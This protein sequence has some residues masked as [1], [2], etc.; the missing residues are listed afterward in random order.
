MAA[1]SKS[2]LVLAGCG[3]ASFIAAIFLFL[4]AYILNDSKVTGYKSESSPDDFVVYHNAREGRTGPLLE[5]YT[6]FEFRYP[7]S[8]IRKSQDSAVNFVTVER[9]V[10]G[11]TYENLNVGYFATGGSTE[12]NQLLYPQLIAQLQGQFEQQFHDLKKV[13]EGPTKIGLYDGWEGLFTSSTTGEGDKTVTIYTRAVLL[14]TADGAKGVTLLMMGTS[15]SPDL[16]SVEDLGHK[17][18][19]PAVLESFKFQE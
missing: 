9:A 3:C 18:E 14:P 2:P 4:A 12:R 7:K 15:L 16:S 5:N 6:G 11:K 10:D 17:G 13:H 19:L 1:S 8:W